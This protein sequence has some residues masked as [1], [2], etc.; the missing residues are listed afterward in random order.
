MPL[1]CRNQAFERMMYALMCT[2]SVCHRV[3]E[4]LPG[5][6]PLIHGDVPYWISAQVCYSGIEQ[7]MKMFLPKSQ[8]ENKTHNL[9]DLYDILVKEAEKD[10]NSHAAR[11]IKNIK[12]YYQAYH[13]FHRYKD[14]PKERTAEEL[15]E[16]IGSNYTSWR[17]TLR[18][19]HSH[20]P[21][22]HTRFMIEIWRSLL[23][24]GD[25][26]LC[27]LPV[28]RRIDGRIEHFFHRMFSDAEKQPPLIGDSKIYV[29][30]WVSEMGGALIAGLLVFRHLQC[31]TK[32]PIKVEGKVE[33]SVVR[34]AKCYH[35]QIKSRT[36]ANREIFDATL[37]N[38][39]ERYN[40]VLRM[41]H[42]CLD[43]LGWNTE[44]ESFQINQT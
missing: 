43:G 30:D 20:P 28:I 14:R 5:I 37:P 29:E 26:P 42:M 17:Y 22:V 23:N 25:S 32:Y 33:E 1:L 8:G 10:Q 44:T 34:T 9:W 12:S 40:E 38:N 4:K 39:E 3:S 41:H 15:L 11:A 7:A 2:E 19:S 16:N 31:P 18:E 27:R 21:K 6:I 13:S 36:I 35:R 24:L